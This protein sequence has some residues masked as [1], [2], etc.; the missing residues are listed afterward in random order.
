MNN[1]DTRHLSKFQFTLSQNGEPVLADMPTLALHT[2]EGQSSLMATEWPQALGL[3]IY[4]EQWEELAR[5][6]SDDCKGT[7]TC[8]L[9]DESQTKLIGNPRLRPKEITLPSAAGMEIAHT[10]F[11]VGMFHSYILGEANDGEG[12]S[13]APYST[14]SIPDN[15]EGAFIVAVGCFYDS[16]LAERALEGIKKNL[17]SHVCPIIWTPPGADVGTGKLV[18]ISLVADFPGCPLSQIISWSE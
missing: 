14:V 18:E 6:R 5:L 3:P 1:D 4:R 16:P 10:G 2:V 8:V 7:L 13:L 17:L 15:L 9:M 12:L 11:V